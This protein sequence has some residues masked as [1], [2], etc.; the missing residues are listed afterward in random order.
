MVHWELLQISN[1]SQTVQY[2]NKEY[3]QE[4]DRSEMANDLWKMTKAIHAFINA[5]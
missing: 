3:E 5:N 2:G 4:S 1:K